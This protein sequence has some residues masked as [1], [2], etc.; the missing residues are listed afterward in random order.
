M[1]ENQAPPRVGRDVLVANERKVLAKAR[2]QEPNLEAVLLKRTVM[3]SI[4]VDHERVTRTFPEARQSRVAD[5]LRS[6]EG[7]NHQGLE[8][9]RSEDFRRSVITEPIS[10][11]RSMRVRGRLRR[12]CPERPCRRPRRSDELRYLG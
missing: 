5:D 2:F 6:A 7:K 3:G 11:E 8:Y 12:L 4:V 10:R 1:Q 9:R